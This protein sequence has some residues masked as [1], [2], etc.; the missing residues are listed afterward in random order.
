MRL[1]F[2]S[3]CLLAAVLLAGCATPARQSEE[4]EIAAYERQGLTHEEAVARFLSDH[5]TRQP[6]PR[7]LVDQAATDT[8][9]RRTLQPGRGSGA[10]AGWRVGF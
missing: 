6:V 5:E 7:D 8:G 1:P 3:P 10:A 9:R 4:D 2:P